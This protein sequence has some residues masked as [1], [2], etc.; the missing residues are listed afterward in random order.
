MKKK[1]IVK[2]EQEINQTSIKRDA[3]KINIFFPWFSNDFNFSVPTFWARPE[4]VILHYV[5]TLMK[6]VLMKKDGTNVEYLQ[7]KELLSMSMNVW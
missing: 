4:S 7:K 6:N 1:L 3:S 2:R 5:K